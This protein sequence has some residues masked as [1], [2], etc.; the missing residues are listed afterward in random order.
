MESLVEMLYDWIKNIAV[1]LVFTTAII[2]ALPET[3]YRPYIQFYMGLILMVLVLMPVL[4][5]T[6]TKLS[7]EKLYQTKQYE[8]YLEEV[9]EVR[10]YL[11]NVEE[12]GL[13]EISE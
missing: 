9:K 2:Q 3:H 6:K 12:N 11:R 13:G 1:Y 7:F 8:S 5:V 10:S 4:H